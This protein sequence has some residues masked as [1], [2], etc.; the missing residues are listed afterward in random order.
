[1]NFI[2]AQ[3]ERLE[4]GE[5]DVG[6]AFDNVLEVHVVWNMRGSTKDESDAGCFI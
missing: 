2:V 6:D 3:F 5:G 1:M 4:L